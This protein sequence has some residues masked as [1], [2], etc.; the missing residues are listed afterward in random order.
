T[1]ADLL[2]GASRID[3]SA[4]LFTERGGTVQEINTGLASNTHPS[5]SLDGRF[6]AISAADPA[7]PGEASG[8]LFVL[9]LATGGRS[10]VIDYSTQPQPDGS[11][12][13]KTPT[14]S[15]ISPN[16]QLIALHTILASSNNQQQG[17]ATSVLEL[18]RASDGFYID[19]V[20][21]G[22]GSQ[23]NLLSSEFTGITWAPDGSVFATSAELPVILPGGAVSSAPGIVAYGL[24][25]PVTNDWQR[26]AQLS[27]PNNN[28]SFGSNYQLFPAFSP[29]GRGIAFFKVFSPQPNNSQPSQA[30]LIVANANGSGAT[31]LAT[32]NPGFYPLGVDW[33]ADGST[34]IFSIAQQPSNGIIFSPRGDP[35]TAVIRQ[36]SSSGGAISQVP[37]LTSGYLPSSFPLSLPP[38]DLATVP[39]SLSP[40]TGGGFSLSASGLNPQHTYLLNGGTGVTANESSQAFT[41]QEIMNGIAIPQTADRRFFRLRSSP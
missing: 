18:F 29:S 7:Q 20:E 23:T 16:N 8:D 17:G 3:G 26:V 33:S 15:A 28:A 22:N 32:F 9:D 11:F 36:I 35:N 24:V 1:H 19:L 25:D 21:I 4:G 27:Q 30:S 10:K 2:F 34:L 13:F 39:L 38:V 5:L 41:G 31:T 37:G 14:Y 40:S 6:V 12:L